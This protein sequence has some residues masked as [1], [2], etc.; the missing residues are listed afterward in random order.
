MGLV[1]IQLAA[2]GYLLFVLPSLVTRS[3]WWAVSLV[4]AAL[5]PI[6]MWILAHEAVHGGLHDRRAVNDVLGKLLASVCYAAPFELLRIGHLLHH[7]D[8]TYGQIQ[9]DLRR[10]KSRRWYVNYYAG[11]FLK[12]VAP[13]LLSNLLVVL[14]RRWALP[15]AR[16]LTGPALIAR[17]TEPN[18]YGRMRRQGLITLGLM[19]A[20]AIAWRAHPAGLV[21]IY[22]LRCA[23]ISFDDS[24][25]HFQGPPDPQHGYNLRVPGLL[26]WL[27]L[28]FNYHGIHHI[29]AGLRWRQLAT[30]FARERLSYDGSYF[31]V[32]LAQL[33]PMSPHFAAR[34]D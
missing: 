21:A 22:A 17:A 16:R 1:A 8:N 32:A 24:V 3:G 20:S 27:F 29:N 19:I 28:G 23:L 13:L 6:P 4:L 30:T 9:V 11:L 33:R 5:V 14:P 12:P 10:A 7:K 31:A 2:H 15:I 34:P 26:A 25:Y 18:V